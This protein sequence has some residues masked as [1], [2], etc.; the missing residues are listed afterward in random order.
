MNNF[1][2]KGLALFALMFKANLI[3]KFLGA[4]TYRLNGALYFN[5]DFELKYYI[6]YFDLKLQIADNM[7]CLK[8]HVS[9]F[10]FK[11][12]FRLINKSSQIKI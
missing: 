5:L 11:N 10:K 2:K 1:L 6:I 9:N 3:D 4:S 12:K 8:N 7:H